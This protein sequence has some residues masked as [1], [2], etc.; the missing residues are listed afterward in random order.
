MDARHGAKHVV[1]SESESLVRGT[2]EEYP[3]DSQ[4][5]ISL[6]QRALLHFD[7][8]GDPIPKS[9]KT[10]FLRC[11]L[12][13]SCCFFVFI[14]VA[15]ILVASYLAVFKRTAL[16]FP[17]EQGESNFSDHHQHF[18]QSASTSSAVHHL[19]ELTKLP[20]VAGSVEDMA[21][22]AYVK[23][24][25]ERYGLKTSSTDYEVLLSYPLERSLVVLYPNGSH[26]SLS[27]Q[28]KPPNMDHN[29]TFAEAIAPF[30]AY[31]PSGNATAEVVYV[32]YGRQEDYAKLEEMNVNVNGKIVIVRY[33]KVFR[34]DI[35]SIATKAGARAVIIYSDPQDFAG[36]GNSGFFPN[37]EW[38]PPSGVQRGT[39]F[40]GSG[41]PL[42]PGWPSTP[43]SERLS[44]REVAALLPKIPSLPISA[45]DAFIIMSSLGGVVAP[46]EW[47]GGL[48]IPEYTVGAGP[49][50]LNLT[51]TEA[52]KL[53]RIRNVFGVVEGIDEPD[54]YVL[55]GNHRDAWTYGAVDPNSGTAALLEIARR[56]E[57]LRKE[58]WN[59]R[60]TL[61]LCSWDAEEFGMIGSTEWVEQNSDLLAVRA[62]AYLNVDCAVAGSGFFAAATPQLDM[63]LKEVTRE[64][65]DPDAPD[66]SVYDTWAAAARGQ[67]MITRLGGGG[68]D[69]IGFLQHVGVPSMDIYFGEGKSQIIQF[70]ILCMTLFNG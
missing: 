67:P 6:Q 43:N 69:F 14:L 8:D 50:R 24:A 2:S 34:G 16:C 37:S 52:Q 68:S 5:A 47:H 12:L 48:E 13:S 33:G 7:I 60:R 35:V 18:V 3:D 30:H 46:R 66:K 63:L 57:L 41:D 21:T 1:F 51:Y 62:I 11:S 58:G 56:L 15:T 22:A 64:V 49:L 36:G 61:L 53:T 54:R 9:S 70:I 59:P 42:T 4:N 26:V 23:Q 29:I 44:N 10:G 19:K 39:V 17:H 38:L 55:L 27:L 20:H 28:E 45:S 65:Q 31:A 32:N 25:F 40:R